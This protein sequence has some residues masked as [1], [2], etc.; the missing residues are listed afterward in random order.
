MIISFKTLSQDNIIKI[1]GSE[2]LAKVVRVKGKQI[3][4][5]QASNLEGPIYSILK[6]QVFV[7]QYENGGRAVFNKVV[8]VPTEKKK[9]GQ[10]YFLSDSLVIKNYIFINSG[11]RVGLFPTVKVKNTNTI[12]PTYRYESIGFTVGIDFEAGNIFYLFPKR[13]PKR[14]GLGINVTWINTG[15][16]MGTSYTEYLSPYSTFVG[17]HFT[18][19]IAKKAFLDLFFKPGMGFSYMNHHYEH[20]FQMEMGMSFRYKSFMIGI[21]AVIMSSRFRTYHDH[22]HIYPATSYNV[23]N[24]FSHLTLKIG[25]A[26]QE[27]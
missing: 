13:M 12:W 9:I 27:K 19:E 15:F 22:A 7:I 21:T 25:A 2:I 6:S 26:I 18:F 20:T 16:L 23:P 8:E 17:P 10:Q 24:N 1:D 4:Y 5:K 3:Q 11:V 14:F